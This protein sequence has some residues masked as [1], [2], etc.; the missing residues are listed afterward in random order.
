MWEGS[1][2]PPCSGGYG[3]NYLIWIKPTGALTVAA[4][5]NAYAS[6]GVLFAGSEAGVSD[7]DTI[8]STSQFFWDYYSVG[9][10]LQIDNAVDGGAY[11]VGGK[12]VASKTIFGS[13]GT[14]LI[15][16]TAATPVSMRGRARTP[17]PSASMAS[18]RAIAAPTPS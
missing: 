1:P 15:S 2:P 4:T 12:D 18:T 14:D 11:L 16:P 13:S 5:G 17:S 3:G 6:E 8:H 7:V 10:T 9:E